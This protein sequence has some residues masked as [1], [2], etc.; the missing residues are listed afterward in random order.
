MWH[1]LPHI[2]WSHRLPPKALICQTLE[3]DGNGED[4]LFFSFLFC[5]EKIFTAS[6]MHAALHTH[7]VVC[8][9]LCRADFSPS[10]REINSN[11]DSSSM[12]FS[13]SIARSSFLLAAKSTPITAPLSCL[14]PSPP[15]VYF[16]LAIESTPIAA[17]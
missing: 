14:F 9:L 10:C 3:F 17:Q 6:L 12:S 2:P 16:H 4:S 11:H 15:W 8:F 5:V 7:D 1:V 13:F